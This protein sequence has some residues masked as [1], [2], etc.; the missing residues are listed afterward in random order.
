MYV[1]DIVRDA[2]LCG[3]ASAAASSSV[4]QLPNV[5]SA[6][7]EL[8]PSALRGVCDPSTSWLLVIGEFGTNCSGMCLGIPRASVVPRGLTS[9]GLAGTR[10]L[11]GDFASSCRL[12]RLMA[13]SLAC[14]F[15]VHA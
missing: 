6:L 10:V 8:T 2:R 3:D 12:N 15:A 9:A 1:D 7:P 5:G 4:G 13:S 11:F 14:S